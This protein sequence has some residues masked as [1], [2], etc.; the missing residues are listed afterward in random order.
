[1][2]FE[3]EISGKRWA[4][5]TT[6]SIDLSIPVNCQEDKGVKA[7]YIDPPKTSPVRLGD[8]IG[9]VAQGGSVNFNDLLVNP[10]AHG[11]HTESLGHISPKQEPVEGLFNEFFFEALVVSISVGPDEGISRDILEKRIQD[12][13]KLVD[14]GPGFWSKGPR[15]LIL[16]TLPNPANK[17]TANYDHKG[18]PYLSAEA[19]AYLA[20]V[21]VQHLLIDTPS[22]DPEK[23]AGALLAH[24]AFWQWPDHPRTQ[25]TITEFIFVPDE[26]QDGPYLLELQTAA[27]VNDATFSRPLIYA[28]ATI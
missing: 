1:M 6:K 15:A 25:A 28:L 3:L 4:I 27:I 9:N 2:R 8:W 12:C 17:L 20:E 21:K 13:Q 7:W 23:D 11:T 24:K 16:R 18:W 14:Q 22:V 10:H 26:I 19:A 5:D